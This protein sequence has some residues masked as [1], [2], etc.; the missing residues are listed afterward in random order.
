MPLLRSR[1]AS[2]PLVAAL[3][4]ALALASPASAG[5]L[6][7]AKFEVGIGWSFLHIND[8]EFTAISDF[9]VTEVLDHQ[10]DHD[11]ELNGYK[12]TAGLSGLMPHRRGDWLATVGV[13]GFYSRYEDESESRCTFTATTDCIFVPLVDPD[14]TIIDSSGG[15][16]SDWATSTERSVTYWGAAVE[17]ALA[18]YEAAASFKDGGGSLKDAP[19]PVAQPS[20]FVWK[21]GLGARR[22]DQ[23]TDL[24]SEDFGPT[25]DPVTLSDDLE[26]TYYGGYFGL[27]AVK[28][29]GGFRLRLNAETGLYYANTQY[30]GAYTATAN[31][32]SDQPV[33]EAIQL[34]DGR[35]AFIGTL[36]LALERDVGPVTLALFGEAEWLSYAPKVLYNDNDSAGGFPFDISGAQDG[37]E[38]G[39]GSAL[40]YTVGAKVSVPLR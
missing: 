37:T 10:T 17:L 23:T 29:L 39:G 13:K 8:I 19:V 14:P 34:D 24:F 32:G 3:S 11:G 1:P 38:L 22:L 15:F 21:V 18:R 35:A 26:T 4:A 40:T 31:L 25:L 20:P 16:F 36:N 6:D 30:D 7:G 12:L 9:F 28:P 27:M 5:E 33:A 2:F